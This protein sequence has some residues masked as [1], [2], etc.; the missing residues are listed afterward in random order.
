MSAAGSYFLED[1]SQ[2]L[3]NNNAVALNDQFIT[4]YVDVA[5]DDYS[6]HAQ[7]VRSM[8]NFVGTV[9]L[10]RQVLAILRILKAMSLSFIVLTILAN[11]MYIIFVE[12]F[13]SKEVQEIAGGWRDTLIR[14]FGLM[15]SLVALA[16]EVD[17]AE[18]VK[19]YMGLKAFIPR[20][21][22]YLFISLITSSH[23]MSNDEKNQKNNYNA[24]GNNGDDDANQYDDAYQQQDDMY[25]E[26]TIPEIPSSAVAF[27]MVTSLVL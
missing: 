6:C 2:P 24:N 10:P 5:E 12:V 26:S 19:L 8:A 11:T 25:Y 3:V 21:L 9:L 23:P 16:I 15:L 13:A 22:L 4:Q 14:L 7:M 18:V 27:Q 20:A 1:R 17:Y